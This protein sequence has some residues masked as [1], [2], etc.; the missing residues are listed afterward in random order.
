MRIRDVK[1]ETLATGGSIGI[2]VVIASCCITPTL[3]LVFSVSIGALGA[4]SALEPYQPY[5][6]GVGVLTLGFAG[7]RIFRASDMADCADDACAADSGSRRF[8]RRLFFVAAALFALAIAYP[9]IL[10]AVF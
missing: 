1:K 8:T 4:L 2:S 3:F 10:G 6:I 5:F 9:Y 7:H